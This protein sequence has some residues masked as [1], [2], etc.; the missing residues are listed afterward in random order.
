MLANGTHQH[1]GNAA[2]AM[3]RQ[4]EDI[5]N[6]GE[7]G[8]VGDD[9]SEADLRVAF[10]CAK[11]E[12]VL[13]RPLDDAARNVLRPV[14]FFAEIAVNHVDVEPRLLRANCV[15]DASMQ[16]FVDESVLRRA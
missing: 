2:A 10:V 9:T 13:D 15:H 8:E 1:L 11:A 5:A 12:R 4:Y 7:Y 3:R 14:R 16:Q 6:V